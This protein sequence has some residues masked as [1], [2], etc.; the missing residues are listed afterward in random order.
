MAEDAEDKTEEPSGRKLEEA[1]DSGNLG[2]SQDLNSGVLMLVSV[3]AIA[4][5]G[6]QFSDTSMGL[7]R[8]YL[9][10]LS[11]VPAP[12]EQWFTFVGTQVLKQMVDLLWPILL[13]LF[14]AGI[15]VNLI[16]VGFNFT[17]KPLELDLKKL[18]NWKSLTGLFGKTAWV[19]LL[20]GLAKMTLVGWV[21]Y[22]CIQQ[23][24]HD[25]LMSIDMDFQG[26]VWLLVDTSFEML[27]KV[28]IL[29]MI[30]GIAD[31]IYQK[32]KTHNDLKM[33]KEEAKEE[34]RNT[35]GD[36]KII[37]AR[38]QAMLKMH[39]QFMMKEVPTATVVITNPTFIAIAVRY[40]RGKDSV[41]VVVAKGKRLIAQKIR[42]IAEE[43][44]VPIV[45]NKPLARGMYDFV[46]PGEPVPTEF[47]NG[48]AEILAYVFN[49]ENKKAATV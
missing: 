41:P 34:A 25:L 45:E 38:R 17:T 47:F 48:V 8:L 44:G 49:M 4:A 5:F 31:W 42:E 15:V 27:W 2:R 33:T 6:K 10:S 46:Q 20:K 9:G 21:A 19:E 16:Q 36:P 14:I 37:A 24:Y 3:A 26:F 29:L 7:M 22:D 13:M 32:R 40:D 43:S 18:F 39:R 11:Y 28:A 12:T 23:R 35:M 30:L 1:R